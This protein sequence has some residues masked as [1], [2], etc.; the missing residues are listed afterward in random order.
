MAETETH[1]TWYNL[2][3]DSKDTDLWKAARRACKKVTRTRTGAV[4]CFF[5]RYVQEMEENLRWRD[6]RGFFQHLKSMEGEKMRKVESQ[7]IHD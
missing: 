3:P 5:E 1:T 7:C 2:K 4:T 6:R